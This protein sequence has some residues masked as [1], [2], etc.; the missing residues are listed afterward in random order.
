[1]KRLFSAFVV[2]GFALVFGGLPARADVSVGS[3]LTDQLGKGAFDLQI[4]PNADPHQ[5]AEQ[6]QSNLQFPQGVSVDGPITIDDKGI[7]HINIKGGQP[8]STVE[9]TLPDQVAEATGVGTDPSTRRSRRGLYWTAGAAA[10]GGGIAAGVILPGG[11]S[12]GGNNSSPQPL[13]PVQ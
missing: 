8:E 5:V 10:A 4:D 3:V 9:V 6:L 2:L 13:S 7:A 11:G 12:D 1:M